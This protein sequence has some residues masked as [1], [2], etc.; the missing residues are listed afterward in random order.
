[1]Q[2]LA[3]GKPTVVVLLN[4]GAVGCDALAADAP[5]IAE[6]SGSN[7]GVSRTD[8]RPEPLRVTVV[9]PARVK[10]FYPS[11]HGTAALAEVCALRLERGQ[12]AVPPEGSFFLSL[13]RHHLSESPSRP[14]ARAHAEV[15]FGDVSPS[16]RMPYT[17][18]RAAYVEAVDFLSMNMSADGGRTYK[19]VRVV[20]R[21][22]SCEFDRRLLPRRDQWKTTAASPSGQPV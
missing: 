22:R 3:L 13:S 9:R 15:L 19:Y 8:R 11:T 17:T 14:A 1:M 6:V 4:G 20:D 16:G 5:A 12:R 21:A 2:V 18:P 10:A 7:D